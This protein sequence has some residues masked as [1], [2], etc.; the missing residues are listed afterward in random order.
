MTP[1][2][3]GSPNPDEYVRVGPGGARHH[4]ND[5]PTG[6]ELACEPETDPTNGTD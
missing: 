5:I 2:D 1:A 3:G 4:I 6:D